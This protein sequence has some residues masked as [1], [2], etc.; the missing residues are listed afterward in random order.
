MRPISGGFV[1]ANVHGGHLKHARHI[2][3]SVADRHNRIKGG[4]LRGEAVEIYELIDFRVV[5]HAATGE[6][7]QHLNIAFDIAVLQ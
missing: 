1:V 6:P 3:R 7:S 4:D 2:N 5:D